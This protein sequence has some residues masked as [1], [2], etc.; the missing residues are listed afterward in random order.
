MS[1]YFKMSVS[2]LA[3]IETAEIT[4]I[5]QIEKIAIL[6]GISPQRLSNSLI[7]KTIS[8]HGEDIAKILSKQEAADTRDAFVKAIY[9]N[10]FIYIVD[11][12]NQV[13]FKNKNIVNN[14]I[15]VLDIFGFENFDF[16]SFEQLCINYANEHLQQFFVHHIFKL[17]QE[18]YTNEGIDWK[19]IPFI[20]N[21]VILNMIAEKPMSILSLID[22]ESKFP[23]GTDMTM[24]DK[25]VEYHMENEHF[26]KPKYKDIAVFGVNHFAGSVLYDVKDFLEKNRDSYSTDLKDLVKSSQNKF[27]KGLFKE[28]LNEDQTSIAKKK[29]HTLASKFRKSLELLMAELNQCQP[30]FVRCIK[31]NELKKAHLFDRILCCRQL[32]YSGMMETAKIRQA[33]YPIRYEYVEFVKRY[34][35]LGR[36][37][38]PAHRVSW[39]VILF[40]K[41]R[42]RLASTRRQ[43]FLVRF[44][45]NFG[46]L[47]RAPKIVSSYST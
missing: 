36:A 39:G 15:G 23:K 28:D 24:L 34:R 7:K 22:D 18:Q 35:V 44:N 25:L 19:D 11:K 13:I 20:D 37:I 5:K 42:G 46:Y 45:S 30:Y 2:L 43:L 31:P 12:I 1:V 32:R 33:G 10:L 21:Q 40:F 47:A 4:D 8:T 14:Y 38:P 6:M 9:G 41:K 16:N 27:L 29:S 17:E 26:L 3:N